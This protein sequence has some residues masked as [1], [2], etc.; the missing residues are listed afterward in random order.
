M[1]RTESLDDGRV[2]VV[3]VDPTAQWDHSKFPHPLLTVDYDAAG[4]VIQVVAVGAQAR[5]MA[6]ETTASLRGLVQ[7]LDT[8]EDAEAVQD[9]EAALV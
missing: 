4:N 2:F 7:D 6:E 8:V 9:L 5:R 3:S 1:P